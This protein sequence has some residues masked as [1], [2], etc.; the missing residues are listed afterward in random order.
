MSIYA[1]KRNGRPTGFWRVEVVKNGTAHKTRTRSYEDALRI[2]SELLVLGNSPS[3]DK[4]VYRLR[5]LNNDAAHKLWAGQKDGSY[6]LKR[7]RTCLALLGPDTAVAEVRYAAMERL[8]DALRAQKQYSNKTVNRYLMTVSKALRW[9][10]QHEKI[11][12]MPPVPRLDEGEGRT[13]YLRLTEIPEFLSWL[14]ANER[15]STALCLEIL[16]ITGMRAGEFLS[17]TPANFEFSD[18]GCTIILDPDK[19]KT[20][21]SRAIPL[22]TG[23]G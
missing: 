13:T 18:E 5:D 19:T 14:R 11:Q 9:A 1:E 21:H 20:G 23:L 15:P 3:R 2:E 22:P 8:T 12:S 17:L 6:A 7:W 16:L 10:W 4:S